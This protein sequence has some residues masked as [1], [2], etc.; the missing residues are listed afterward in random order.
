[1]KIKKFTKIISVLV[2]SV[3]ICSLFLTG[4]G[5]KE[6]DIKDA[7]QATKEEQKN[8]EDTEVLKVALILAGSISDGSW[9][10]GAYDGLTW[11]EDNRDD[12][13][14]TYVENIT[15]DDSAAVLQNF[16]D[17]GYNVIIAFAQ[18]FSDQVDE[19]AEANPDVYFIDTNTSA[20]DRPANVTALN[21]NQGEGAF[22]VGVIGASLSKTGK[23]GTVEGFEFASLSDNATSYI[24]GAKYVNPDIEVV[25]SY[26]G[27]WTDVE[28]AKQTAVAQIES[29]V[30]FIYASGDSIGLGII[31]GCAQEGVP[32]IGYGSDLNE[33]A[34]EYVVSTVNWNVGISFSSI[35]NKIQ[36]GTFE[37][38]VYDA[39]LADGSIFLADYHGTIDEE[40]QNE[41]EKVKEK[42]ISGEI[43]TK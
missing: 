13:E 18:E 43:K 6:S 28:K 16:V 33:L 21:G 5:S 24:A 25:T 34:P 22:L 4:C 30:D 40:L 31:E 35:F 42:I 32:V 3:L 26:V 41:V 38:T 29:G 10:G 36:D 37:S 9:N 15:S 2:A 17:E 27:S 1:M 8:V 11:L 12:I 7:E 14:T 23:I 39:S 20:T 19:I